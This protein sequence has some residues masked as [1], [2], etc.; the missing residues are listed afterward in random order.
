MRFS[1]ALELLPQTL[2]RA[3]VLLNL[4]ALVLAEAVAFGLEFIG[5]L[6][7]GFEVVSELF[8]FP[9]RSL[10]SF[11]G[12]E[13]AGIE[14]SDAPAFGVPILPQAFQLLSMILPLGRALLPLLFECRLKLTNLGGHLSV[15]AIALGRECIG[16]AAHFVVLGAEPFG[17][18]MMGVAIVLGSAPRGL[19]CLVRFARGLELLPQTLQGATVLLNSG[20]LVLGE[21][22]AFRSQFTGHAA[23]GFEVV[24]KLF[25]L[26][27]RSLCSLL[28]FEP[29]GLE[30]RAPLA[31]GV[32]I[33]PQVV[34]LLQ[35]AACL[36]GLGRAGLELGVE[37]LKFPLETIAVALEP[38][39][40]G[41]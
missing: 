6:A 29:I 23:R 32:P 19:E 11:L 7:R 5:E 20:A 40:V 16:A 34:Q 18:S 28:G 4:G 13:S 39:A 35:P 21:A 25:D 3:T 8:D 38:V 26:P 33:M 37:R 1:R 27:T 41:P 30:V 36:L 12:L 10:Y 24:A 17:A 31:F 9:T 14:L 2:Q 15:E 22:I